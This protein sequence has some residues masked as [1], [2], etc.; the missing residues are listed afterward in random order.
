L[1]F[2]PPAA[3]A[4][5]TVPKPGANG[6]EPVDGLI[7]DAH[8]GLFGTTDTGGANNR[9]TVFEITGSGF[10]AHKT[11]GCS[12]LES[13]DTFVFAPNLGE[14]TFANFKARDETVDHPK[15]GFADLAASLAQ[16]HQ[17]GAHPLAHDGA[18]IMDHAATLA[19]QHAHH[20][21]V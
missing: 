9:G 2:W 15:S 11:L 14:N 21:L 1:R 16:A 18:D 19:A 13:H 17:D 4:D 8:G 7:A 12:V 3:T 5:P 20:F 6:S 10:S